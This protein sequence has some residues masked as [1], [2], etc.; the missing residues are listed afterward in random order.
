MTT[1]SEIRS[2]VMKEAWAR[3]RKN[4]KWTGK[5]RVV[6]MTFSQCLK[7]AWRQINAMTGYGSKVQYAGYL[8]GAENDYNGAGSRNRYFGD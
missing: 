2:K 7:Y 5:F 8:H 4:G 3:F 1:I 6:V